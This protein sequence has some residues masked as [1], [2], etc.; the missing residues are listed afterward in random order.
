MTSHVPTRSLV[1]QMDSVVHD[2]EYKIV[3]EGR[4]EWLAVPC[5]LCPIL[6]YKDGGVG[7]STNLMLY[8]ATLFDQII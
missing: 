6:L 8:V 1:G 7:L 3:K 2:T 4:V 5:F